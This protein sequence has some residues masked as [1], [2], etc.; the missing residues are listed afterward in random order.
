MQNKYYKR[1]NKKS[2]FHL[3]TQKELFYIM[4]IYLVPWRLCAFARIIISNLRKT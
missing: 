3:I 4:F 1:Q 2:L